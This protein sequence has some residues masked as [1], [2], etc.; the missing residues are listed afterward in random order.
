MDHTDILKILSLDDANIES[1]LDKLV[2]LN[3][4][5]VD[6]YAFATQ[7]K[8]SAALAARVLVVYGLL[9]AAEMNPL[10]D[11]RWD[12]Q[13][14]T[15]I[16]HYT[17]TSGNPTWKATLE[18][19]QVVYIRQENKQAWFDA[20]YSAL[21]NMV[22][23]DVWD[24]GITVYTF[25]GDK[26]FLD[27]KHIVPGGTLAA[28]VKADATAEDEL[29]HIDF[30]IAEEARQWLKD[31]CF[32]LDT[33]TTGLGNDDQIVQLAIVDSHGVVLVDT[34]VYTTHPI[35]DKAA[36]IHGITADQ[37]VN[38]PTITEIKIGDQTLREWLLEYEDRIVTYNA[39]FDARLL[40]Q[41]LF[42]AATF[43]ADMFD[44]KRCAMTLY[45]RHNGEWDS[46]KGSYRWVSLANACEAEDLPAPDHSALADATATLALI[47]QLARGPRLPF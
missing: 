46:R 30:K 8:V 47:K 7:H 22:L 6:V 39:A 16:T 33:E 25:P 2:I 21:A 38:A 26:N 5:L 3:I 18:G 17:S 12:E 29:L 13:R 28:P 44:F 15:L 27:C 20:G 37:L 9:A 23:G 43:R 35:G 19:G 32:V 45:A 4:A 40:N 41:S 34:L 1:V 36:A 11:P 10:I 31:G 14:V 42:D 24:A